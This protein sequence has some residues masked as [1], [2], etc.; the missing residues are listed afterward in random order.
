MIPLSLRR[1]GTAVAAGA[2]LITV[3]P[4]A[5]AHADAAVTFKPQTLTGPLINH[6][7][8]GR[9]QTLM[10]PDEE[11][12]L[13]GGY[14]LTAGRGGHLDEEPAD[15]LESRPTADADG[16]IVAVR[17]HG[18]SDQEWADITLYVV[19]TQGASTPGG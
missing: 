8:D 3:L 18:A 19:C 1:I 5:G 6:G 7:A 9:E 10:C 12:V 16:W 4:A 11:S 13:S 14:V 2:A 15:V 17:K